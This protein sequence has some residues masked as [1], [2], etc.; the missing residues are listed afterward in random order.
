MKYLLDTHTLLWSF[1]S[2]DEISL[3]YNLGKLNLNNIV[4]EELLHAAR[5]AGL[6]RRLIL[7]L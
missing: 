7:I 2:P 6:S 1:F 4:Q 3:K 5:Q